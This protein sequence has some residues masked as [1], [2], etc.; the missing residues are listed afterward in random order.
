MVD[1]VK[2]IKEVIDAMKVAISEIDDFD[3]TIVRYFGKNITPKPGTYVVSIVPNDLTPIELTSHSSFPEFTI[4][5]IVY[6]FVNK[7]DDIETKW[8][9]Y[10][11]AFNK[12]FNK[13]DHNSLDQLVSVA[14]PTVNFD[15]GM[16][17]FKELVFHSEIVMR[18]KRFAFSEVV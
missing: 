11:V 10:M 4:K 3:A 1:L 9:D 16:G 5:V 6:Y 7:A 13:L 14:I 8:I 15:P 2:T 17:E 12:V 18:Y